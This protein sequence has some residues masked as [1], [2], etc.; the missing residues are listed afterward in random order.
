MIQLSHSGHTFLLKE[1]AWMGDFGGRQ[2]LSVIMK[3]QSQHQAISTPGK[4]QHLL[5]KMQRL[6]HRTHLIMAVESE[7]VLPSSTCWYQTAHYRRAGGLEGQNSQRGIFKV[8]QATMIATFELGAA[9]LKA[10]RSQAGN[11]NGR[12]RQTLRM[13]RHIPNMCQ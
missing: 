10:Q 2:K 9:I 4:I 11:V 1:L 8:R 7:S 5:E 12:T 3:V 6:V 13:W